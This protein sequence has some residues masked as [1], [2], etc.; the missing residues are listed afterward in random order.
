MEDFS[1]IARLNR[2]VTDA[3]KIDGTTQTKKV[4]AKVIGYNLR[5]EVE[6]YE[7][8]VEF[9]NLVQFVQDTL[10]VL[11]SDQATKELYEKE[12][13]K[14]K[15]LAFTFLTQNQWTQYQRN[16]TGSVSLALSMGKALYDSLVDHKEK[17]VGDEYLSQL[18]EAAEK[19]FD[20]IMNSDL[21]RDLRLKLCGDAISIKKSIARYELHGLNGIEDAVSTLGGRVGLHTSE[22]DKSKFGDFHE[23]LNGMLHAYIKVAEAA[24][25]TTALIENMG[26]FAKSIGI[27][28]GD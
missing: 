9:Y 13:V 10:G 17:R 22:L 23:K 18:K 28:I 25:V 4:W 12:F 21:P 14:V 5:S 6:I 2:I 8:S 11:V 26:K 27:D 1:P 19:L 20:S 16:T 7:N 24:N 15:S 3:S